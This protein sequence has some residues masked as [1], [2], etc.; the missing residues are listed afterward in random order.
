MTSQGD[1]LSRETGGKLKKKKQK[2]PFKILL[3]FNYSSSVPPIIHYIIMITL[4]TFYYLLHLL[5][6]QLFRTLCLK[7]L[8]YCVFIPIN[9]FLK[10]HTNVLENCYIF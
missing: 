9:I 8:L 7:N 3:F 10:I 2:N 6:Q 1:L 5:L 4:F